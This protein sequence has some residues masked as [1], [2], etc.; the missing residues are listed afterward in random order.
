MGLFDPPER[1]IKIKLLNVQ[2]HSSSAIISYSA[3]LAN[4]TVKNVNANVKYLNSS[5]LYLVNPYITKV[6]FLG[7]VYIGAIKNDVR[8]VFLVTLSDHTVDIVQEKVGTT[9]CNNLLARATGQ[10]ADTGTTDKTNTRASNNS[11]ATASTNIQNS[12]EDIDIPIEIL[13]NLYS[14][15][16]SNL[17][18]KLG[19]YYWNDGRKSETVYV[20]CRVNYALNGRK[21]GK[22]YIIFTSYDDKDG[23]IEIR[24]D[25]DKYHFT[26]AG[27]EFVEVF[28]PDYDKFPINKISISIK[29]V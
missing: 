2:N 23:V 6:E 25:Y 22:R 29:E 16:I 17:S 19:K 7:K 3:T 18:I 12:M 8:M 15:S 21:E 20:K 28:F 27:Y 1:P 4:K 13:P 26:A 5:L 24:G 9:R 10:D 14:L 11:T